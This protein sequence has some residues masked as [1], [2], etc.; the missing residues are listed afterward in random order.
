VVAAGLAAV[1]PHL[2]SQV[3]RYGLRVVAA[4]SL[5]NLASAT[6]AGA[7]LGSRT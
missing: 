5:S 3:A 7:L 1:E 6:I 4:G 2:R